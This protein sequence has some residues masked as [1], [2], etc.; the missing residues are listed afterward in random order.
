MADAVVL[1]DP[2]DLNLFIDSEYLD[3]LRTDLEDQLQRI[4]S[5]S[6]IGAADAEAARGL[7]GIP[8]AALFG[9]YSDI[10][11]R[12]LIGTAWLA[13]LKLQQDIALQIYLQKMRD[14]SALAQIDRQGD[15]QKAIINLRSELNAAAYTTYK[16]SLVDVATAQYAADMTFFQNLVTALSVEGE[17]D[18]DLLSAKAQT[19]NAAGRPITPPIIPPQPPY[20]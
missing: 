13:Y 3:L 12:S 9:Q 7:A 18:A 1:P 8:A 19:I 17:T 20:V 14:A 5:D 4:V 2:V 16:E 15:V 6:K 10:E 11:V